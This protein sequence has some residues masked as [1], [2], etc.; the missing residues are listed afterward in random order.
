MEQKTVYLVKFDL[1]YYAKKQPD[2]EWSYTDDLYAAATFT[3]LNK[4]KA[5]G[6]W[7]ITLLDMIG[8]QKP[9]SYIIEKYT[10]KT[11]MEWAGDVAE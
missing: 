9:T 3:T 4:A 7:G 5:R 1:G 2:Y 10:V 6:E 8:R 11:V